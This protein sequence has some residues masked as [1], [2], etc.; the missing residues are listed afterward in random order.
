M[1]VSTAPW[2]NSSFASCS[3]CCSLSC[4]TSD[5]PR[6]SSTS[7]A[8]EVCRRML[9]KI[10]PLRSK[11]LPSPFC[12]A[13]TA[14]LELPLSTILE[15]GWEN[16]GDSLDVMRNN[17]SRRFFFWMQ[18]C[19]PS[20]SATARLRFLGLAGGGRGRNARPISG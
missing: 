13:H 4:W 10:A 7:L 12:L 20:I 17:R 19:S 6:P 9:F 3:C 8:V 5:L 16:C 11:F 1:Y 14:I 18:E 15:A 2:S